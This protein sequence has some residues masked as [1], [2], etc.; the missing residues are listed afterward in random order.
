MGRATT[1]VN[2][3]MREAM[4]R[5]AAQQHTMD[6]YILKDT[7]WGRE[8]KTD[9]SFSEQRHFMEIISDKLKPGQNGHVDTIIDE[10]GLRFKREEDV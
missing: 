1:V 2:T 10:K 6:L 8:L 5:I 4:Y 7:L 3:E 9:G